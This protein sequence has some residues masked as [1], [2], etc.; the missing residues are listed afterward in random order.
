MY[1]STAGAGPDLTA[2]LPKP[3]HRTLKT[4]LAR[5]LHKAASLKAGLLIIAAYGTC[6]MQLA[7]LA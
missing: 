7:G 4:V 1:T 6:L 3:P 5:R 2:V